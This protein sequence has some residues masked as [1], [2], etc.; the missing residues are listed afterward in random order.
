MMAKAVKT[1]SGALPEGVDYSLKVLL[2]GPSGVGK[3]SLMGRFCSGTFDDR[4]STTIGAIL[5]NF[6]SRVGSQL[7]VASAT[8]LPLF[9]S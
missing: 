2:V 8:C 7:E 4:V 1:L 6:D 3:T 5:N 9:R